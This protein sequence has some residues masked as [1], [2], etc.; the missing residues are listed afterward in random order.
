MVIKVIGWALTKV[1]LK[2]YEGLLLFLFLGLGIFAY[3]QHQR[4]ELTQ[5]VL[6]LTQ[7][8]LKQSVE[9]QQTQEQSHAIDH[10]LVYD[11]VS[12]LA[13]TRRQQLRDLS[14]V[15]KDYIELVKGEESNTPL[16][17]QDEVP[18]ARPVVQPQPPQET[19]THVVK[20]TQPSSPTPEVR[21]ADTDRLQLLVDRM[22]QSYCAAAHQGTDCP[23][24]DL[25][26]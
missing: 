5:D 4:L 7:D 19:P 18:I 14:S 8:K 2:W 11:F 12:D 16:Y 6:D 10:T 9:T 13:N 15:V 20:P 23:T 22:R 17:L 26:R 3:V 21:V 1:G 25:H 24:Q